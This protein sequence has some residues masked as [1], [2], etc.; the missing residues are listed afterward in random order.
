MFGM[1][2]GTGFEVIDPSFGDCLIGHARVERLWTG[3]RWSEGP[4][5]FAAGRYLLWSD[6]P[7]NRL[8]RF[9]ET[10]GS[11][12][13]FRQPSNN[14]NGNTV[15]R[16]GRLV[17]CE[18]LS[19]RVTRTEHDGSLTVIADSFEG[20]R[21]NSPNDV[22]VHSDGSIWFTDPSYGILMDY[23]GDR[24]ESEI[25]ACHVYRVDPSGTI[26]R[27][28]EDYV[29]PNGLA[30]SPDE[31]ELYIADTGISHDPDGPRHIRRHRLDADGRLSGGE[32]F[33]TC[34]EGLFDGFRFD[35]AGRIWSS[36]ADGVHCL[37]ASG[38]LIG[39]ILIPELVANVC[40]GGPKLNRLFICGTTSLYS[41]FLNVNG[42][43]PIGGR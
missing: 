34:T 43:S 22:V 36:A 33:A 23:E 41:V 29:K 37:D 21:L 9:D 15:D 28:I 14:A 20:K 7:N 10:D 32:V 25:G 13:T 1:I 31:T 42:V 40:F 2:E 11:V 5:W 35:R 16:Q 17:T 3:A 8:L 27:M 19:R 18:H 39:K 12:S 6:I 4:V 26:A 24:A 30:F 38:A